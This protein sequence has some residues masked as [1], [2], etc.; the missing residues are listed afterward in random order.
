MLRR[1]DASTTTSSDPRRTLRAGRRQA[2]RRGHPW[3]GVPRSTLRAWAAMFAAVL[4][5]M[6][7]SCALLLSVVEFGNRTPKAGQYFSGLARLL[8]AFFRD[9][10]VAL[11]LAATLR[12]R[13]A[14]V[15][16][17]EAL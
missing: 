4:A 17:D 14:Q 11:R 8:Q 3:S 5:A 16:H 7:A 2:P 15:G 12:R 13:I 1:P 9:P 10:E 6:L